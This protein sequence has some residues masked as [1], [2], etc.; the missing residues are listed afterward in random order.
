LSSSTIN[1]RWTFSFASTEQ[2]SLINNVTLLA[3]VAK[4]FNVQRSLP[5]LQR[6]RFASCMLVKPSTPKKL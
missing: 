6:V 2:A 4:E 5:E 3:D 1:R